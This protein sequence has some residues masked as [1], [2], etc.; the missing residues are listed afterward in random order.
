[1]ATCKDFYISSSELSPS[2]VQIWNRR[3]ESMPDAF[4]KLS[5]QLTQYAN[6][7]W[8]RNGN[9]RQSLSLA[10]DITNSIKQRT[11]D[12]QRAEK[13]V[14]ASEAPLERQ[15]VAQGFIEELTHDAS[16]VTQNTT[17]MLAT[18]ISKKRTMDAQP[19]PPYSHLQDL[20][21]PF[22][23][24]GMNYSNV[25]WDPDVPENRFSP[26]RSNCLRELFNKAKTQD[27]ADELRW[28]WS[29]DPKNDLNQN[30]QG[31]PHSSQLSPPHMLPHVVGSLFVFPYVAHQATKSSYDNASY[32]DQTMGGPPQNDPGREN[33]RYLL[34]TNKQYPVPDVHLNQFS[35]GHGYPSAGDGYSLSTGSSN[36]W[37]EGIATV[38]GL[39][40]YPQSNPRKGARIV[41][42]T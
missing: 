2:A 8:E 34:D 22:E 4:Y 27:E 5:E 35:Q 32:P 16:P 36:P 13:L 29:L 3:V 30:S 20:T 39:P 40:M 14:H 18:Q 31:V 1:M 9:L 21:S 26:D 25:I 12:P 37:E 41:Y 7:N 38:D 19:Q 17:V 33:V 15:H 23:D 24:S 11:R 10:F 6:G 42:S 28:W